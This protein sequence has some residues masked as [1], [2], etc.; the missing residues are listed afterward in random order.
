MD[1]LRRTWNRV[2]AVVRRDDWDRDFDEEAQAHIALAIDDY[3]RQGVPP[4]EAARLARARFGSVAASRDA[5]RDARGLPSIEALV[6]DV[7]LALRGLR[8]DWTYTPWRPLP[9]WRSPWR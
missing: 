3:L 4:A 8:R 1:V 6:F 7:R 5:H 9:C 2:L